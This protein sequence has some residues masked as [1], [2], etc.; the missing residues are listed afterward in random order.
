MSLIK[1]HE[2]QHQVSTEA[3][4]C[5]ACG[6]KVR[7][8]IGVLGWI[9]AIAIGI[10]IYDI[11]STTSKRESI[12]DASTITP[13]TEQTTPPLP[14]KNTWVYSTEIDKLT[15]KEIKNAVI[16]SENRHELAFPYSGGT[17]A[18]IQIRK[19]PR[20]GKDVIFIINKGQLLCDIS[21]GC[22]VMIRFDEGEAVSIHANEPDDHSNTALFLSGYKGLVK[23]IKASKKMT[24]ETVF[25]HE[26]NR[27][28]EFNTDKLQWD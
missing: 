14:I 19:H 4:V 26:G 15:S 8:P 22:Q 11:S 24:V 27:S 28:F 25:F 16:Q 5:P 18:T 21:D 7:K 10:A 2:C 23:S 13:R 17:Y 1:C 12:P 3:K 9:F 6:A 20:F